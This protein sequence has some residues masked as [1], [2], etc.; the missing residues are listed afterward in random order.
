MRNQYISLKYIFK[1]I[2]QADGTWSDPL[3]KCYAP[4]FVENIPKGE[5]VNIKIR[6]FAEHGMTINITC[7]DNYELASTLPIEC[8]NGTWT[9]EPKCEPARCKIL[10]D[11]PLNGMVVVCILILQPSNEMK[12]S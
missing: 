7:D 6:T 2:L 9:V 5:S 10:P 12:Y 11:P 4:C 8:N 1:R 3:P